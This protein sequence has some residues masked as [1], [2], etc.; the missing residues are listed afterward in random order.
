[1]IKNE[2]CIIHIGMPKTGSSTLQR[3]FFN[4][5]KGTNTSYA[6]LKVENQSAIIYSLF[7]E[8]PEKQTMH[9]E[10]NSTQE[11]IERFNQK[12]KELLI[13]HFLNTRSNTTIISGEDIFHLTENG[14]RKMQ[15]FLS[16]YF[17]KI[18]IVGY[19][20][21]PISYMNSAF[22]Q[23]VK[24]HYMDSFDF[25][26]IYPHYRLKLEKFDKVFGRNNVHFIEFNPK[27]FPNHDIV[28]DFSNRFNISFD[29]QKKKLVNE[30][31]SKELISI[32]F[33]DNRFNKKHFGK[34]NMR[35][36]ENLI[37]NLSSIGKTK[38]Y[39]SSK[40]IASVLDEYKNDINWLYNRM[41]E[42][43]RNT[44]EAEDNKAFVNTEEE[45]LHVSNDTFTRLIEIVGKNHIDKNLLVN[46]TE[47]I[48]KILAEYKERINLKVIEKRG[49]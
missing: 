11:E 40:I 5:I 2:L 14:I 26:I 9:R 6:D 16:D 15:I 36:K 38:F 39:F 28:I 25:N 33:I 27:K 22:Q 23:L 45:L 31:I 46:T 24:N 42:G 43:F 48:A 30:S 44:N 12:N 47:N 37:R 19:I 41:G 20:R 7:S 21:H 17:K 1:M 4:S 32:L 29:Y 10:L 13:N 34:N 18:I 35:V 3:V 49:E 8:H